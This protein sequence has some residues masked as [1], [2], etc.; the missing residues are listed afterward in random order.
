MPIPP[1]VG[2]THTIKSMQNAF[3]WA[4]KMYH[5]KNQFALHKMPELKEGIYDN[6]IRFSVGLEDTADLIADLKHAL[7]TL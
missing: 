6:L 5:V 2:E 1:K 7:A 3:R 4:K